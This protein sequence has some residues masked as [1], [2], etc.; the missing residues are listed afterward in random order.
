[1]TNTSYRGYVYTPVTALLTNAFGKADYENGI[2][3]DCRV[4]ESY[5]HPVGQKGDA[6]LDA[7]LYFQ[8]NSTCPVK[9]L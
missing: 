6:L 7:V 1:M 4:E 9:D 8:K 3:P 5:D 2:E